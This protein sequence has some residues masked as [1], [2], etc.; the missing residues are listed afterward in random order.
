MSIRPFEGL[1]RERR[2]SLVF[3]LLLFAPSFILLMV[4]W[5]A[6]VFSCEVSEISG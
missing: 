4:A 5:F 3:D 2:C 1:S 6:I